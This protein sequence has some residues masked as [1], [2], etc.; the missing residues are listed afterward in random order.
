M[1]HARLPVS[2]RLVALLALAALG[3]FA[4]AGCGKKPGGPAG[5]SPGGAGD[6]S[7]PVRTATAREE[8]VARSVPATGSVA[9]TQSVD[10]A[11]KLS[12]RVVFV[13]GR[14][15]A[16]VRRGQVVIQQDTVDLATQVQ[17]AEANVRQ[18]EASLQSALARL[19]QAQTQ[20]SMQSSTSTTGVRDAEQQLRSAQAQLELAQRPQRTQ[21][22]DVAEN[23]VAQAQANYDK[24]A[25]DRTRY[26][27]L[28]REGAA[29]QI[30]LDQ[31]V[32]QEKVARAALESAKSQL[33]IAKTGGRTES[34]R[35]AETAV[36]RAEWGLR[37]AKSNTQQT[38]VRE[39]DIRA[40]RAA[41]AQ[42]KAAVAQ[43]KASLSQARLQLA[44][45]TVYS[46]IDGVI[47]RRA[48][49][50][51]QLIGP[52]ASA[53]TVVAL[54]TVFFEAQ[55]PETEIAAIRPEMPVEVSVDAFAGR[56]FRGRVVRAY[57]TAS[58]SSRAFT[59]RIEVPNLDG[60]LRPGMFARGKIVVEQRRGIVIPKDALVT[61]EDGAFAVFVVQ[62]EKAARRKVLV[63]I[64]TPTATEI[65]DGLASGDQVIVAGQSG[66]RDGAAVRI[67]SD[68]G[69]AQTA[70]R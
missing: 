29:A 12:A 1:S 36:Q 62:G 8:I 58:V 5:A 35:Q 31:Y 49:E 16:P 11:P 13:A 7:T 41:V 2:S 47:S 60:A 22:V 56:T 68:S 44:S 33:D 66:L 45:A 24:A 40:A 51:G 65:R 42:A 70:S 30:Q 52:G 14:E 50:P 32:A 64:Q 15:G 28:V 18:T 20:A 67:A 39:D 59:V 57:P 4:A 37:L 21:E 10:L 25:S 17:S 9:A 23:A 48:A 34:V 61:T 43:A 19:A 26:E 63:G 38:R 53:L 3:A 6:A 69:E 46:P 27:A 55:V 54:E